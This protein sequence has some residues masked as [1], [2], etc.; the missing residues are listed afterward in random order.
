MIPHVPLVRIFLKTSVLK[1]F[2]VN[3]LLPSC[4]K[5]LKISK[6]MLKKVKMLF[7]ELRSRFNLRPSKKLD[8][9]SHFRTTHTVCQRTCPYNQEHRAVPCKTLGCFPSGA[10][11]ATGSPP[12][13]LGDAQGGTMGSTVAR[14][15]VPRARHYSHNPW[16]QRWRE[17]CQGTALSTHS[18]S[19]SC[20]RVTW[21]GRRR[22]ISV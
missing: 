8:W 14:R 17:A 6:M 22:W 1:W 12:H 7:C 3:N 11:A 16:W 9:K 5:L 13:G 10:L 19:V 20:Q 18:I 4:S 2:L 21:W 15:R